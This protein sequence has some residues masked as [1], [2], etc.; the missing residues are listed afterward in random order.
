[1][2]KFTMK[3]K[4][5]QTQ[6]WLSTGIA[7]SRGVGTDLEVELRSTKRCSEVGTKAYLSCGN[8]QLL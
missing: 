4:K 3:G 8:E 6:A 1:M 5:S 7:N 2:N